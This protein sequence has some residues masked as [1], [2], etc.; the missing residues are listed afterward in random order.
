MAVSSIDIG[1]KSLGDYS[2]GLKSRKWICTGGLRTWIKPQFGAKES[3]VDL[4]PLLM[5]LKSNRG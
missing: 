1:F 2:L 3:R 4:T 5:L